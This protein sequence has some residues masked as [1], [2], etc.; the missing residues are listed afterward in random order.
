AEDVDLPVEVHSE[1]DR[2]GE[3][4]AYA[5]LTALLASMVDPHASYEIVGVL[6]EVFGVSDDELARFAQARGGKFQIAERTR[7]RGLVADTLNNLVRLRDALPRQPLFTAVQ[8]IVRVTQLRERLRSLPTSEFGDTT[9]E[10]DR[11]LS[12]AAA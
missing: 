10:L 6:R 1:S 9:A 2:E 4:P 11:L 3:N 7:E 12:T 5:W 8:E